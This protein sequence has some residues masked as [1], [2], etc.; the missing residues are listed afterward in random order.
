[1]YD[2]A[3]LRAIQLQKDKARFFELHGMLTDD[4]QKALKTLAGAPLTPQ[5][6][7]F[8]YAQLANK[9]MND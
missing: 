1:M 6:V 7:A 5:E 4:E 9:A 8:L 2:E 3:D